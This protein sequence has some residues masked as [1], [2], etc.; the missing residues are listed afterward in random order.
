MRKNVR[1]VV[2]CLVALCLS[3]GIE[4]AHAANDLPIDAFFGTFVGSGL[5][6]SDVSDYFGLTVRD[7]D[8]TIAAAGGGAVSVSWTTVI[9]QGGDPDNPDVRRKSAN[10]VLEPSGRGGI[11]RVQGAGDPL[12][13]ENL[14]WAY[15]KGH[16]LIMHSLVI[17]DDGAYAMQTYKRTLSD[18][19]MA[20]EFTSVSDGTTLRKVEARLTKRA[21]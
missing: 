12:T 19:G 11:Y 8:V 16:S 6:R 3:V 14:A 4:R 9:R 2:Y 18:L 1:R 7:L 20:L 17:H 21:N 15:V 13:G 10:V 5:A